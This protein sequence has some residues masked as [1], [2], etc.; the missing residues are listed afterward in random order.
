MRA[1]IDAFNNTSTNFF[2]DL[3]QIKVITRRDPNDDS[4]QLC[5]LAQQ[6]FLLDA[7]RN[8]LAG[9]NKWQ[10]NSNLHSICDDRS[11]T[12]LINAGSGDDQQQLRFVYLVIKLILLYN[13]VSCAFRKLLLTYY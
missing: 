11:F 7:Q 13:T 2:D 12:F 1:L 5:R 4:E 8:S 9:D 6:I 3:V 10:D